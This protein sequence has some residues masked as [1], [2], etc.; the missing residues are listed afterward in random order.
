MGRKKRESKVD[1]AKD[2]FGDSD[3]DWLDDEEERLPVAPPPPPAVKTAVPLER[4]GLEANA[5]E[6]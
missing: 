2:F 4:S 1:A 5:G 3:V 6:D